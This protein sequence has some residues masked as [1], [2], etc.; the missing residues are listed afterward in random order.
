MKG[1]EKIY[2]APVNFQ[3]NELL[4]CLSAELGQK[5]SLPCALLPLKKDLSFAFNPRRNQYLSTIILKGLKFE[6]PGDCL[7][8]LLVVDQDLF[9]PDLNFVFGEAE[10]GGPAAIISLSRL[11]PEFY[12]LKPDRNVFRERTAK[13]AVHELGHTFGLGHC[14]NSTCVMF[15][16]NSLLDTDRKKSDFCLACRRKLSKIR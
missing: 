11:R 2:I 7:R 10:I 8:I 1:L 16:S 15:F 13:E 14:G 3:D 12:H 6:I 4:Q 5:F 9:V